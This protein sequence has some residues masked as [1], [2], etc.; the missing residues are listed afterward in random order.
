M[1]F[2]SNHNHQKHEDKQL[3]MSLQAHSTSV[4]VCL[5]EKMMLFF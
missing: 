2:T 1:Q 5:E 4:S 3:D